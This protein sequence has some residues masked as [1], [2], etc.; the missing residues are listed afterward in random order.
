MTSGRSGEAGYSLVALAA[1]MTIM[2]I[3]MGAAAPTWRYLMQDMREEELLFRGN[4][5]AEAIE[6]YQRKNG[7]TFPP[8][9][10]VLVKG[11]YLRKEYEDPMV[12]SGKWRFLKPGEAVVPAAALPG[13]PAGAGA[14]G[15][16]PGGAGPG[17][18]TLGAGFSPPPVVP[19][20]PGSEAT[21]AG[22][23]GPIAGVVSTSPLTGYRKFN[24][25]EKYKEWAFVAG[26][27]RMVGDIPLGGG[28]VP[29]PPLG[30]L[31]PLPPPGGLP[32]SPPGRGPSPP[33][34][35]PPPLQP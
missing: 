19:R 12:P 8:S 9:L 29:S 6:R 24:N 3:L 25:R 34:A 7:N 11:K 32:P 1:G 10:E 14:A 15:A 26:Q 33:R 16:G 17:G 30:P 27:P 13:A 22:T 31:G 20:L 35:S 4:Q 23:L 28:V 2:L 21:V 5:I 18:G